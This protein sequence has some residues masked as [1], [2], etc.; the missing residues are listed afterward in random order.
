MAVKRLI[1][2]SVPIPLKYEEQRG[3]YIYIL[4][5]AQDFY[6]SQFDFCIQTVVCDL[7]SGGNMRG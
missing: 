5:C 4:Q 2:A 3:W 6:V 1:K 7:S